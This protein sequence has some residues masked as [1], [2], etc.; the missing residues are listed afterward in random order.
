MF[1]KHALVVCGR[2]IDSACCM[3]AETDLEKRVTQR[4]KEKDRV[5]ADELH[6]HGTGMDCVHWGGGFRGSVHGRSNM[7]S[8]GVFGM[9][10]AMPDRLCVSIRLFEVCLLKAS[11]HRLC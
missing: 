7:R 5:V 6:G 9:G 10:R 2:L 8:G 3:Q 1:T 4:P 11:D